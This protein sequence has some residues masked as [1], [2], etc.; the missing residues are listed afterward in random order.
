MAATGYRPVRVSAPKPKVE[1]RADGRLLLGHAE[2]LAPHPP[3]LGHWLRHWAEAAPARDFLAERDGNGGWR[4]LGYAEARD[5]TDRL[6]AALLAHRLGPERPL[7][8]LSG[9]SIAH[10][11]LTFA[12]I[13]VGVPV[14]PLSVAYST[15]ADKDKLAYLIELLR[16]GMIFAEET[17]V[18]APALAAIEPGNAAVVHGGADFGA[19]LATPADDTV[20][21]AFAAAAAEDLAKILFTSGST[22]MPKGVLT[23]NRMLTSN[24]AAWRQVHP[25]LAERPPVLVDWL[26]WNHCFGGSFV[27]NL[28]LANGGT[29]YID[30]GKPT[31]GQFQ[32]TLDCL[33]EVSPT[34]YLNVPAGIDLLLPAL[35]AD[36]AFREHFFRRLELIFY[37]G[38]V[39]PKPLWERL[40]A[41]AGQA[42]GKRVLMVTAYGMTET[43]PMHTMAVEP[44][45]GPS[46]VGLPT[47]DSE[48]L[49]IPHD[50]ERFE[51]RCRG[52]N[53]MPGYFKRDDLNRQAFDDEGFLIT[54]DAVRWV[55]PD[56]A[57]RGLVFLGRI[58]S[59][60][61]L[62]TGTWVQTDEVRVGAIAAVPQVI[63]DALVCGADKDEIGLLIFPNLH[64]CRRLCPGLSA[65]ASM[66][67]V[68]ARSEVRQALLAGLGRYNAQ[69]P[70]RSRRIGRARL[71]DEPPS[72]YETE[73]TDKTSLNQRAGIERRQALAESLY[74]TP[75]PREV[76]VF[77]S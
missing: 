40:E 4:R 5:K 3:H 54:G 24:Q 28:A 36:A 12:A 30:P 38:S 35:E 17:E 61:K 72:I 55:D 64:G 13:Q 49:L 32:A 26:P 29:L 74:A 6:S 1:R 69:F 68:V 37:A 21:R 15:G 58:G 52:V 43:G 51:I 76:I 33:A 9:N 39:L 16:P 71:L 70:Y 77:E 44:A 18:F 31:P 47:P 8:I 25:F 22:G 10:A 45:P 60:F 19:L 67:E 23:P 11:L 41:A 46:H 50:G 14:A 57:A 34:V 53:V 48:L 65:D 20:E 59:N 2:P 73:I 66:G 56:D 63:R 42:L 75:P 27:V 7:A 62:L